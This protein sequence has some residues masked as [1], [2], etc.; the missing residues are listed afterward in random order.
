MAQSLEQKHSFLV[1]ALAPWADRVQAVRSAPEESR[2][3]YREKVKLSARCYDGRWE[4]GMEPRDEFVPIPRCPV[5]SPRVTAT[6]EVLGRHL[7][8]FE[9]L[10][11]RYVVQS[12]ALVTLVVKAKDLNS[13]A[14]VTPEFGAELAAAGVAGLHVNLHP[15]AG[16]ILFA[17]KGWRCLWGADRSQETR[18]LWHGPGAFG[19]SLFSLHDESLHE[20]ESFFQLR[21]DS[22]IADFYSGIGAGLRHWSQRTPHVIGVE[23]DGEAASCAGRNAP[24]AKILRGP[25]AQRLP[26]VR[27]W[28]L[29]LGRPLDAA[30]LYPPRTGLEDAVTTWLGSDAQ[31]ARIAYLSRSATTLCRD[32]ETLTAH[33]YTVESLLPFDFYPQTHHVEVLALLSRQ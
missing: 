33:G 28:L 29:A 21:F 9:E 18:G 27:D 11:V 26:Q 2:L 24:G 20:A 6:L 8:R 3:R 23:F 22:V 10:P 16:R 1:D 14:W 4:F 32:L 31:P 15:A 13:T 30:Y 7:P 17:E 12:G 5:Q 25:C 19:H